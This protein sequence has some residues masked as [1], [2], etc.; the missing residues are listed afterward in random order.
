VGSAWAAAEEA[1]G[2]GG[3]RGHR[4][5]RGGRAG[6]E[7]GAGRRGGHGPPERAWGPP[8]R[9]GAVAGRAR[10]EPLGRVQEGRRVGEGEGREREEE[11]GLTLG[12]K[13]RR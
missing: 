13:I 4:R 9:R 1:R 5:V 6:Y 11:R 2:H 12:S 8:G 7:G 10:R 3:G